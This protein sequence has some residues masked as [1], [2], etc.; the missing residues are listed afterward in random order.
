MDSNTWIKFLAFIFLFQLAPV[1]VRLCKIFQMYISH[2][3]AL[4]RNTDL[5]RTYS[6]G[7]ICMLFLFLFLT[8]VLLTVIFDEI[9]NNYTHTYMHTHILL[10]CL[11]FLSTIECLT[12]HDYVIEQKQAIYVHIYAHSSTYVCM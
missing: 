6:F 7:C 1:N 3:F 4:Y 5:C 9:L 11:V 8:Q 10:V 2:V 12:V